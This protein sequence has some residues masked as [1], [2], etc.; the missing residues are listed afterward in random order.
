MFKNV[1]VIGAGGWGTA[2]SVVLADNFSK[3][4]LWA[5]EKEV[6]QSIN[7]EHVNKTFFT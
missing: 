7:N 1:A 5:R 2:L 4:T 6:M 3:V